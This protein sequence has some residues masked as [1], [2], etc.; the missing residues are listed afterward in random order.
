MR[1][2]EK[3]FAY[4]TSDKRLLVF[5]HVGIPEAGVQVP[6]GSVRP[7]ELPSA[8]ATRE[9]GEETG[10]SCFGDPHILGIQ[11]FDARPYGKD[12]IHRRHF[13]HLPLQGAI[14]DRWR[15]FETDP[16]DGSGLSIEFECYWVSFEEAEAHLSYG[17]GAMID[18]LRAC[19]R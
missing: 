4:I 10:L 15:S 17:H 13:F 3:A 11:E 6:G 18:G 8:A 7:G 12:E 16:S 19:C 2:V 14:K 1:V 9:A 5:Q